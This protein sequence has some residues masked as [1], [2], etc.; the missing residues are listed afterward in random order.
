MS[1]SYRAGLVI[2]GVLSLIDVAGPLLT[3]GDH[4]PMSIALIGAAL[5]VLSLAFVHYAWHGV[6]RA[7]LPLVVLRL[8]AGVAMVTG[9]HQ[10]TVVTS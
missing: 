7:V 9:S 2:L 1:R 3:D 4:P 5:G 10:R 8:I 6:R